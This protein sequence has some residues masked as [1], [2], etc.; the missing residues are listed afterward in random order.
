MAVILV[1]YGDTLALGGPNSDGAIQNY[2]LF[3]MPLADPD[4]PLFSMPLGQWL[5]QM[6]RLSRC[7]K[8]NARSGHHGGRN[9][10]VRTS[11]RP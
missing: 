3:S 1:F 11:K 4:R 10:L 6:N 9:L 5:D 2:L 8:N 7:D